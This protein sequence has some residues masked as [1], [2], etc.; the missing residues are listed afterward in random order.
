MAPRSDALPIAIIGHA[1]NRNRRYH[2]ASN[3]AYTRWLIQTMA[4]V[5]ASSTRAR[6]AAGV[7][8]SQPR[9]ALPVGTKSAAR[10]ASASGVSADAI[11]SPYCLM[12]GTTNDSEYA[13]E[14]SPYP[15]ER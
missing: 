11:H 7:G 13:L 2:H 5:A 4:A 14:R 10:P 3:G 9:T 12:F 8:H 6:R 1:G 15:D